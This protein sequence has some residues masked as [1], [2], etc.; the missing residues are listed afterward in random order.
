MDDGSCAPH[1]ID[2][3]SSK[4]FFIGCSPKNLRVAFVF[5]PILWL[6]IFL[7]AQYLHKDYVHPKVLACGTKFSKIYVRCLDVIIINS[8]AF[9][10]FS[11]D[12]Q[13]GMFPF[14]FAEGAKR[15]CYT[16]RKICH[17]LNMQPSEYQKFR[18]M[19]RTKI[20]GKKLR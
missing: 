12:A 13:K 6:T 9:L 1:S 3:S 15:G 4:D 7:I 18:C 16:R 20:A 19:P 11:L 10:Q 14:L 17:V 8:S 5:F 2:L